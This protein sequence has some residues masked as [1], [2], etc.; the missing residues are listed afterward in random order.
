LVE[1]T[2]DVCIIVDMILCEIRQI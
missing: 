1:V 2:N